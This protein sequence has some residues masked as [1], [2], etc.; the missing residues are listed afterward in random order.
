MRHS[1]SAE[2]TSDAHCLT[3]TYLLLLL[4]YVGAV[5]GVVDVGSDICGQ[6]WEPIKVTAI[7]QK[8]HDVATF[9]VVSSGPLAKVLVETYGLSVLEGEHPVLRS[10]SCFSAV[11]NEN[12]NKTNTDP[13]KVSCT[14]VHLENEQGGFMV[15]TPDLLRTCATQHNALIN[16]YTGASPRQQLD[17]SLSQRDSSWTEACLRQQLDRS[18]SET[19]AGQPAQWLAGLG[20]HP[21]NAG[22]RRS[23][24]SSTSRHCKP[25]PFRTLKNLYSGSTGHAYMHSEQHKPAKLAACTGLMQSSTF[26]LRR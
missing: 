21:H 11:R 13:G 1:C 19:A 5:S 22:R 7:D 14:P 8:T 17:R 4:L 25:V 2:S 15:A 18:V 23:R 6:S 10:A 24:S 9:E 3:S 26:K 20:A 12:R 16:S